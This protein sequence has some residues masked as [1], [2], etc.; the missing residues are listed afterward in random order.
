M[1]TQAQRDHEQR[2][3][4]RIEKR[5]AMRVMGGTPGTRGATKW[6]ICSCGH[7]VYLPWRLAWGQLRFDDAPDEL[8]EWYECIVHYDD[9]VTE[10]ES[11]DTPTCPGC[12]DNLLPG[13][14]VEKSGREDAAE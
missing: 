7:S 14:V 9:A 3:K 4:E 13:G 11:Y 1:K 8:C 12:G 10:M 2:T 5:A 6:K